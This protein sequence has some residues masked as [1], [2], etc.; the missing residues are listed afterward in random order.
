[1]ATKDISDRT[2]CLAYEE[3]RLRKIALDNNYLKIL[4]CKYPNEILYEITG[5]P[6]KVCYRAMERAAKRG[7]IEYGVSLRTGW[8]TDKGDELLKE[9]PCCSKC[10]TKLIVCN[11]GSI[12]DDEGLPVA[13]HCTECFLFRETFFIKAYNDIKILRQID[14]FIIGKTRKAWD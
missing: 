14:Q 12:I 6:E 9:D 10:N 3:A 8:L 4:P 7:Y 2:V 5:Q 13:I 11:R 1:M